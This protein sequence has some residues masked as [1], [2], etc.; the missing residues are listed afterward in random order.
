MRA[1]YSDFRPSFLHHEG[2]EDCGNENISN[3]YH[4]L[5]DSLFLRETE[6]SESVSARGIEEGGEGE[7]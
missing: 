2:D 3:G 1:K 4:L 5:N 7:P 6:A